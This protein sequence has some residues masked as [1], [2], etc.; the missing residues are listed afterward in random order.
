MTFASGYAAVSGAMDAREG[1]RLQQQK[2]E[3]QNTQTALKLAQAGYAQSDSGVE[4][5]EGGKADIDQQQRTLLSKR[6]ANTEKSLALADSDGALF[7]FTDSG[8][9][10]DI[11]RALN[12][13]EG[14]R[15]IWASQGVQGV[16]NIDWDRDSA[17]LS[18]SGIPAEMYS[19]PENRAELNKEYFKIFDGKNYSVGSAEE[20]MKQTGVLQRVSSAKQG[21]LIDHFAKARQ[22]KYADIF[23]SKLDSIVEAKGISRGD[24]VDLLVKGKKGDKGNRVVSA[25]REKTQAIADANNITFSEQ[26]LKD[27]KKVKLT[28][29]QKD[30]VAR[31]ERAGLTEEALEARDR[32]DLLRGEKTSES[33]DRAKRA[34]LAGITESALYERERE[35]KQLRETPRLE[36][37]IKYEAG[38]R[39]LSEQ[40][41]LDERQELRE[42]RVIPAALREAEG[43]KAYTEK[44]YQSFGGE[45]EFYST[46]FSDPK[47]FRKAS[48]L[49]HN[50]E[51]VG[52]VKLSS[53]DAKDFKS[54]SEMI[55]LSK[56][57][58]GLEAAT[59]GVY[60]NLM[61]EFKQYFSDNVKG[62]DATSS[63]QAFK[64]VLGHA[65]FGSAFTQ[66]EKEN[67]DKAFGSLD[68][69]LGPVLTKFKVA[70]NQV[71][72]KLT[73][74]QRLNH[75]VVT[76]Y[77][78]GVSSDDLSNIVSGLDQR[79]EYI[80]LQTNKKSASSTYKKKTDFTKFKF[81]MP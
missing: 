2:L 67:L 18:R 66:T 5:I 42:Q 9:A 17:L 65:L 72:S 41:I 46:D 60:D 63:H 30:F 79:L 61:H 47:N 40:E 59:T 73:A 69:Q 64:N 35:E 76:K 68:Q 16:S 45:N 27:E 54:I 23:N 4:Q 55:T 34:E 80:D 22:R 78:L 33:K 28:T 57:I 1:R 31:A 14:L 43:V 20:M 8:D 32:E 7:N 62:V 21:I 11:Q 15:N 25:W 38:E 75:P 13:N 29:K 58:G 19:S 37:A 52:D 77:R 3:Q 70:I 36:R 6:L 12:N 53:A 74:I 24:A 48:T 39:G 56:S 51:K 44:L 71:R 26:V 50:I 81:L 49:V 10:D